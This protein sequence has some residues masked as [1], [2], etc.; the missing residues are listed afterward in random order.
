[1]VATTAASYAVLPRPR[2]GRAV[3]FATLCC[4]LAVLVWLAT[5]TGGLRSPFLAA[6]LLFTTLFVLLFPTLLAAL[7]PLLVFPVVALLDPAA[8]GR[9]TPLAD[10]LVV[11]WYAALD[12]IL[13]YVLV[14]LS[15]RDHDRN[16]DQ[17]R[18]HRALREK[19]VVEERNRLAREIHD[20][21]GGVLSGVVIQSEWLVNLIDGGESR[22]AVLPTIRKELSELQGAAEESMDELRR[23]LSLLAE[24]FDLAAALEDHCKVAGSRL[25]LEVRFSREG[26]ERVVGPERAMAMFRV[27]Q[28]ALTNAA[29]HC[30]RGT[31]VE[32]Q[33]AFTP[34]VARLTVRDRGPG[35]ELPSDLQRLQRRG[36]YGLANMRERAAKVRGQIQ[37][38]SAP[39]RGTRIVLTVHAEEE[40]AR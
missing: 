28:E 22:A 5:M 4:D 18:L 27:L 10:A 16:G 9:A 25:G 40:P 11:L 13:V 29:K 38:D 33:L 2:A 15:E 34:G 30:G 19:A 23:S 1:M 7:P 37:I 31:A 35:F 26:R 20:G 36:H 14:Y 21:L 39:G 6:Q 17:R 12:C 3:T 32:V 24:N 8:A